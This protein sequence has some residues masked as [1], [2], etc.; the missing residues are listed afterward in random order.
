MLGVFASAFNEAET[1][2][3][4]QPADDYLRRLLASETFIAVVAL[5][6]GVVVGGLAGYVL[7]KFEQARSEFYIYDLAVDSAHGRQGIA[8]ALIE[9]LKDI[10]RQ[11]GI[12]VIYVQADYGD[13]PAVALYTKMGLREDVM[14]FDID[15]NNPA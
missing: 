2:T 12:Y 14:H 4:L 6:E 3:S 5:R 9:E 11:R 8:T 15:P 13:E 1:Y 7:P 10:A